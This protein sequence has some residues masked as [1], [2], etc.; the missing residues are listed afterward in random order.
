MAASGNRATRAAGMARAGV[1]ASPAARWLQAEADRAARL[2]L[3]PDLRY[4]VLRTCSPLGTR[5][6]PRPGTAVRCRVL[7]W[8]EVGTGHGG[9]TIALAVGAKHARSDVHILT[10]DKMAGRTSSRSEYGSEEDNRRAAEANFRHAGVDQHITLFVGSSE[11]FVRSGSCPERI[12]LMMLDA[13]GRIDRDLMLFYNAL[14]PGAPIVVDDADER[15]YLGSV[16]ATRFEGFVKF[17][18]KGRRGKFISV[19]AEGAAE[20]APKAVAA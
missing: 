14:P 13:D 20:L 5:P 8:L 17:E 11:D 9:A 1:V 3:G 12:D 2:K 18:D 4:P 6:W 16:G 7:T 15:V 10:I 19:Y